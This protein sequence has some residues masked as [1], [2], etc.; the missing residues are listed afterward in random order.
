MEIHIYIEPAIAGVG[1]GTLMVGFAT[2]LALSLLMREKHN[3]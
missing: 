1:L 3:G 2:M